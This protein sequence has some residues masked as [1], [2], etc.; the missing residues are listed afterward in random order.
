MVLEGCE[1]ET[2]SHFT[3]LWYHPLEAH[4]QTEVGLRRLRGEALGNR[5]WE[6]GKKGQVE[7]E[8]ESCLCWGVPEPGCA[9]VIRAGAPMPPV[10]RRWAR[11]R[12]SLEGS[13]QSRDS[14]D[15]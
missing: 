2:W 1:C 5:T 3:G 13:S 11:P 6:V 14:A 10:A 15:K 7:G 4:T 12:S 8:A 9:T